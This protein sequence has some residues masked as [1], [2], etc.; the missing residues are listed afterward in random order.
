MTLNVNVNT[1]NIAELLQYPTIAD[2]ARLISQSIDHSGKYIE[3]LP[4]ANI[5]EGILLSFDSA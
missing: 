1:I 4:L 2:H 3:I 5:A